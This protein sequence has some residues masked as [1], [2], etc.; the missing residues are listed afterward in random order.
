MDRPLWERFLT[1][2]VVTIL[3]I[4]MVE[5]CSRLGAKAYL[6][7]ILMLFAGLVL[8]FSDKKGKTHE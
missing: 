2:P 7:L 5:S 3:L 8:F 1:L 6:N 4:E